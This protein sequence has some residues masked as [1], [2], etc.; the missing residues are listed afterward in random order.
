MK[1]TNRKKQRLLRELEDTPMVQQACKKI[2]VARSTYYR[3]CE[4]D[5][6][7]YYLSE[8]AKSKGRDKLNDYVESKLLENIKNGQQSAIQFWL[9]NNSRTYR[10]SS[11]SWRSRLKQL[12]DDETKRNEEIADLLDIDE[13]IRA[14]EGNP[15]ILNKAIREAIKGEFQWLV[16]HSDQEDV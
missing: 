15:E 13:A 5:R 10:S 12:E 4:A 14:L 16:R 11:A 6:R 7:F 3:W 1:Q 2:G 9:I 8:L